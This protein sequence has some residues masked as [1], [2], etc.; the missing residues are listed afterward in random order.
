MLP[1]VLEV[2][3]IWHP[4]DEGGQVAAQQF[5]EH[6]HGTLFSG[7]IGGAVEVY[8]RSEGWRSADDAPRPIPLPESPAPNGVAD[9]QITA[10]VPILGNALARAVEARTESWH[11]YT[12]AIADAAI[13]HPARVVVLPLSLH[14]TASKG[15]ELGRI[16]NRFQRIAVPAA[17][18]AEPQAQLRCRDL[19]QGI[20][21]V[22]AQK[23][24]TVFISHTK[25]SEGRNGGDVI[26]LVWSDET[27]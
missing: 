16:L 19:A 18:A 5:L 25:Q 22:L 3:V 6:F 26:Q 2:Y 4:G 10:V 20:A 11:A 17:G 27:E 24:L 8:T 15:T 12:S 13:A 14:P 9:A 23:R 7:L 21:Q 1:P